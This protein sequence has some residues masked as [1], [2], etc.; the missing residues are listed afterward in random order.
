[1]GVIVSSWFLLSG[2]R[3]CTQG[4]GLADR[5]IS[6]KHPAEKGRRCVLGKGTSF[7]K[8]AENG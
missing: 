4:E 2:E 7:M 8:G 3:R 6:T 1:M 5:M